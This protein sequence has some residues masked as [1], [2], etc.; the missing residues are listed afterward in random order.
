[1]KLGLLGKFH[2]LIGA[3]YKTHKWYSMVVR[4]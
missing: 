1:M 3:P 4:T 2:S